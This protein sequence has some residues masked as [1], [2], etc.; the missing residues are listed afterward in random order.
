MLPPTHLSFSAWT[1]SNLFTQWTILWMSIMCQHWDRFWRYKRERDKNNFQVITKKSKKIV[2]KSKQIVTQLYKNYIKRLLRK[3]NLRLSPQEFE[4]KVER[5]AELS[6]VFCF[7]LSWGGGRGVESMLKFYTINFLQMYLWWFLNST[8]IYYCKVLAKRSF[9]YTQ[10]LYL[11][12]NS[13]M[14]KYFLK[15]KYI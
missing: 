1:I 11:H 3:E 15:I 6:F 13:Y 14:K 2:V 10:Y 7:C 5:N 8:Y 4:R 12:F 9:N